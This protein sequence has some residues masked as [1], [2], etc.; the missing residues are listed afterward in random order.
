MVRVTCLL[1]TYLDIY[2]DS[3]KDNFSLSDFTQSYTFS[4]L[5]L[6]RV[7]SYFLLID[8]VFL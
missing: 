1:K 7:K 2:I 3:I 5:G 8:I 6:P 4:V